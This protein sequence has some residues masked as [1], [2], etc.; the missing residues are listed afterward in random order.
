[1]ARRLRGRFRGWC[2]SRTLWPSAGAVDARVV[3]VVVGFRSEFSWPDS[4]ELVQL[5]CGRVIELFSHVVVPEGIGGRE[6][7]GLAE[8]VMV[9]VMFGEFK[10]FFA[11]SAG[12]H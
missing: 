9:V 3:V 4:G 7:A 12:I 6:P 11:P 8:G 5:A 2:I 1:M 10:L